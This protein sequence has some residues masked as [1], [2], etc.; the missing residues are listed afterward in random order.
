[1]IMN[2]SWKIVIIITN[3]RKKISIRKKTL[4]ISIRKDLTFV[5]AIKNNNDDQISDKETQR[6]FAWVLTDDTPHL[7]ISTQT[8][9]LWEFVYNHTPRR[10]LDEQSK[11]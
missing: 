1:M 4:V 10:A 11:S 9:Y 8:I 5:C 2:N 3:L 6:Q 7:L